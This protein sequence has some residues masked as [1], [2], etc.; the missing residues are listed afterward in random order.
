MLLFTKKAVILI[1]VLIC[2]LVNSCIER[3]APPVAYI[4]PKPVLKPMNVKDV[5]VFQGAN[6]IIGGYELDSQLYIPIQN[7]EE[8]QFTFQGGIWEDG[9]SALHRIYPFW[10][11]YTTTLKLDRTNPQDAEPV[12]LKFEYISTAKE[13]IYAGSGTIDGENFDR[14]SL[15]FDTLT[16]STAVLVRQNYEVYEGNYSGHIALNSVNNY[17]EILSHK[18]EDGMSIPLPS[19]CWLEI[20]YK[21]DVNIDI[22]VLA[23]STSSPDFVINSKGGLLPRSTWTTAYINM[24]YLLGNGIITSQTYKY[25]LDLRAKFNENLGKPVQNIYLDNI[26]ILHL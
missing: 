3:P 22:A 10:K 24:D 2:V 18:N 5:W 1:I 4:A 6:K 26:R 8:K 25:K 9:L 17:I 12:A 7:L 23:K 11:P 19:T 15:A 21:S 20:T 13:A 14:V 16:G